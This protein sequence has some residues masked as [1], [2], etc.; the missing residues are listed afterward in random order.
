[1]AVAFCGVRGGLMERPG[2]VVA[3]DGEILLGE[4]IASG[5]EATVAVL[6]SHLRDGSQLAGLSGQFSAV[7][8]DAAKEEIALIIDLLGSRPLYFTKQDGLVLAASELKALIAAG[9]KPHLDLDGAAQLLAYEHLLGAS[10]PLAGVRLLPPAS[11]TVVGPTGLRT[12]DRGRYRVAPAARVDLEESVNT[13]ARLLD[14]AIL[15]RRE[16]ATALALSGGLDSRCL[17]SIVGVRWPASRSFTFASPGTAES[18]YAARVAAAAGLEH[19]LLELEDGYVGRLAAETVWL[20]EGQIRCFH[21][22][23]FALRELRPRFGITSLLVG[24]AGDAVVRAGPLASALDPRRGSRT[25]N[26]R[27]LLHEASAVA[28]ADTLLERLLTPRFAGELRG[29]ARASLEAVLNG[30]DGSDLACY[31]DYGVQEVYRRKVLPGTMLFEDD[32]VHRDPYV[33]SDLLRFLASLPMPLRMEYSLQRSYLRRFPS[34]ARVPNTKE[35]IAP[36]LDGW[37]RAIAGDVVR[38][39]RTI[40]AR[41]DRPLRRARLPVRSGYSDYTSHLRSDDGRR[42]LGLLLE[43]RTLDRGQLRRDQVRELVD[44]TLAGSARHTQ[45]LGTL[46]TL[47]LFQRQFLD[48]D[49][50]PSYNR[51]VDDAPLPGAR[52]IDTETS[53]S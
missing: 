48:K 15:R 51:S 47:E 21:S 24:Y 44:E 50:R 28:L 39:R 6:Q 31:V 10:T 3:V 53:N 13:F 11:T 37:R 17:A 40:R 16:S 1:M 34:L 7:V 5:E 18:D 43:E 23:H 41:L 45:V 26:F 30:L 35:R 2:A 42:V 8:W 49:A 38:V 20:T 22:H 25:T 12:I 27:E 36:T 19:H 9:Y 4:H 52:R 14:S 33:D 29:R 46:L 32:L